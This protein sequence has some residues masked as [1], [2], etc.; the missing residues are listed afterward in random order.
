MTYTLNDV[1]PFRVVDGRQ[2][3]LTDQERQDIA[4]EWNANETE[5]T[6]RDAALSNHVG[7]N[8]EDIERLLRG[9]GVTT[10]DME[11]AKANRGKSMP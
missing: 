7:L 4:D 9:L 10:I 6:D 2:I 1:V 5:K 11:A 8:L 3:P